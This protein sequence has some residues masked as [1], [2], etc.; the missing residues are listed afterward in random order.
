MDT[1]RKR[2]LTEIGKTTHRIMVAIDDFAPD[3]VLL[4]DDNATNYIGH[5]LLD[6]DIPVV[7]WGV[8]GLPLKY[9]LIDSMDEPGHNV[10][11][12]WQAGYH[13][14]SL[15][16][17]HALV[18]EAK[19]FAILA[20]DSETSRPKIKQ[21]QVLDRQGKLPLALVDV[22]A[23][24]SLSEFKAPGFGIGSAGGRLFRSQP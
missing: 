11:G 8:N 21:L 14:E 2:S 9:S 10:T 17:L 23:T 7:F 3:L 5:E 12:V 13:K 1:K 22:V 6:T 4:G 15:E 24:N 19:T 16:L 20:C 18:P